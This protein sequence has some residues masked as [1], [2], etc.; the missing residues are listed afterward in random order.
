MQHT[1]KSRDPG[2]DLRFLRL[3]ASS[4]SRSIR[5]DTASKMGNPRKE[6]GVN[7]ARVL[8]GAGLVVAP[9]NPAIICHVIYLYGNVIVSEIFVPYLRPIDCVSDH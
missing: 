7:L 9:E 5:S 2:T 8:G 1:V 4:A 3:L 6:K